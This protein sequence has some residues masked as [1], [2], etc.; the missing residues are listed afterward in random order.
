MTDG[1]FIPIESTGQAVCNPSRPEG[2]VRMRKRPD[3][4]MAARLRKAQNRVGE[5]H[6]PVANA[7]LVLEQEQEHAA[8]S[9]RPSGGSSSARRMRSRSSI[10]RARKVVFR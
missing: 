9:T 6:E 5:L 2:K 7:S 3:R 1:S 8:K 10:V 4:L